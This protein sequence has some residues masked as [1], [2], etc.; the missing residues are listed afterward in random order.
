MGIIVHNDFA[1]AAYRSRLETNMEIWNGTSNNAILIVDERMK[2]D[3]KTEKF[4]A[5]TMA[6][7]SQ[8]TSDTGNRTVV[9]ADQSETNSIKV[10]IS[11]PLMVQQLNKLKRGDNSEEEWTSVMGGQYADHEMQYKVKAVVAAL[12]GALGSASAA[13]VTDTLLKTTS[14]TKLLHGFGDKESR[15]N[16]LMMHSLAHLALVDNAIGEK[17]SGEANLVAYGGQP[18]TRGRSYV[19]TDEAALSTSETNHVLFAL[20]TGAAMVKS[21]SEEPEIIIEKTGATA[22]SQISFS[23]EGAFNLEI[24][25]YKYTGAANPGLT[26]LAAV[27]NWSKAYADIKSTAGMM[28]TVAP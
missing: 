27:A 9:N 1:Q 4:W 15:L 23:G 21:N 20:Q 7:A 11:S 18:G 17:V 8:D 26:E 6:V 16:M 19:V 28:L 12:K 22:N 13:Q 24:R 14:L 2:G 25:G 10:P 3:S 5:D